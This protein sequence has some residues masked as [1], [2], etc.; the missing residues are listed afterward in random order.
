MMK[1]LPLILFLL[2]FST[3]LVLGQ[4]ATTSLRGTV[5]D[6]AGAVI[7]GA[8]ISLLEAERGFTQM[9]K[10]NAAGAY[11]F[12]Q[13]TPG[14]YAIQVTAAGFETTTS[15]GIKLVVN[16]PAT[17]DFHLKVG[18]QTVEVQVQDELAVNATDA[19]LGND[20]NEKQILELPSEGRN[21][22]D[23]LSLQPGVSYV[24]N[25][26]DTAA[27]SRGGAVN[28][29]RSD[30][31][32]ITVDGLDDNDQLLGNAFTG[33]LRIP[34]ES[35]QEFRVTTTDANAD[36]GR[37]SGAQVTLVTKTGTNQ[38]HGSFYEYNRSTI[39]QANDWFNK[40]TEL[41]NGLPDIPGKLIRNTFGA[42]LG[43]PVRKD[44]LFYFSNYEGQRLRETQQI[45]ETVPSAALR[46]GLVSYD[47]DN[48]GIATLN[49]S[50][51]ASIDQGCLSSGTCPSGNGVNQSV[52]QLWAGKA[53]LPNG[54]AIPAYPMPNN[55]SASVSGA[56]GLNIQ[57]YNFAAPHPIDQNTFV[58][59]LDYSLTGDSSQRIFVRGNLQDD[60][61]STPP[62]FPGQAPSSIIRTN[63]KG[64]AVGF[65][66]VISPTLINNLRYAYVRQGVNTGGQ[67]Q[68]PYVSFWDI[69]NQIAFTPTT[70]VNVPVNQ[71]LEDVTKT[72]SNHTF[73][74]GANWRIIENNRF[75]NAQNFTSASLHPTWLQQGGIA[76]TGQDLDP[77]INPNL[78]PVGAD[79]GASYDAAITAVTGVLGSITATY[80]QTKDGLLPQEALVP[81]H[82]K[83][84]ELE[85]YAQDN[86][87]A[88]PN[89][90]ITFGL[91]YTLLQP[92][93]ETQG[94]QVAPSPSLNSFFEKRGEAMELGQTYRPLITFTPSGKANG[95]LP[96]WQYDYKDI[97]PR[98]ALAYS[99]NGLTGFAHTIF[100]DKGK[101]SIRA[102]FGIYYDHFGEG[103]V[104]TFDRQG[105]LG[106]TTSL[107]NPST[108]ST[109][110]CAVRFV[111]LTTIPGTNGCPSSLGGPPV[112]EL[113]A[114]P[115]AGFPYTP[116]GMNTNGSFAIGFGLD[117]KLKT[118]YSY[119][120]DLSFEREMPNH[121][122]LELSYVGR[123]GRRLLQEVDLA[124]PLNIKD[125]QS[126]MTYFQAATLITKMADA[127]TPE[128]RVGKIAYWENMFPNAAG[129]S[130]A[131]GYAPGAPGNPTATQNIYDLYYGY[132]DNAAL[133]L[134]S[135]DTQCF[136]ACSKLGQFAYYDDQFSSLY[137]W[138]ST[139]VSSY[140]AFELTVRRQVGSL[141]AD[142][143]YTLS[144]SL[145]ENS[146]AE[147]VN[148][149][150]NG[151]GAAVAF[152]G[153]VVNAWSPNQFYAPS[154][155]DTRH[156][157]NANAIY[158]LPFGRGKHWGSE[159]S[160]L[161]DG[162]V[163]G[164]QL[165]GLTRWSSGYPFSISTYAFATDF[166]QD[167]KAVLTGP[168]P[169]TGVYYDAAG[170]PNVFQ[171]GIKAISSFRNAYPGEAGQ[172]NNLRGPGYFG[173]DGS[174]GKVWKTWRNQ[175]LRFSW[176][177]FN[178]TNSV[179]MD[180][181]SLSNYLF[182]AP[183]LGYYS[184]TLSKP[185][186]MQFGL[187]YAF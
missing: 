158:D 159:S 95:S 46:Q 85:F 52:L 141:L 61:E 96:Y 8:E 44:R 171:N 40:N 78:Q 98:V 91:R 42:T 77:A 142:F 110:D 9:N 135:M 90:Q 131:S 67:N 39:G 130:G 156:Q 80:N 97:A 12:L 16:T 108:I 27:D 86:W 53:S 176:D 23:L 49:Q 59:R 137:S 31:T 119:G 51:I 29:A 55:L 71:F 43:G 3:T 24:G 122:V 113:P 20:F 145:D 101:S 173:I 28:G 4:T 17:L 22:V 10:S 54:M 164:W 123:L 112:P 82:F 106:L 100:G 124:T 19:S 181:G 102:G 84:N 175:Q 143:N 50:D 114:P 161:I 133:A 121:I 81:R 153:Q 134:Q 15:K 185:R 116:P 187:H 60:T 75:S 129:A 120:F 111:S 88:S 68:Y 179:R 26:V 99:P 146:N 74:F 36:A 138:R 93:Y 11:Q 70:N 21:A 166:E 107:T 2:I 184:Q 30:Q 76:N 47:L 157:I 168:K 115:M 48:G 7:P 127:G 38:L 56:D 174:L 57:G 177:T 147:R 35:L 152:S 162:I 33:V 155:F 64:I 178:V 186:V 163:G 140:N 154:D 73:Q 149:F 132:A 160:R 104:N 94:N 6:G 13:I 117:D 103:I 118:P 139:G 66:S 45:A 32:N 89:L 182:Y 41:Q 34:M 58:A 128:N 14:T 151:S 65:T 79:F 183:S 169:K 63:N 172:R 105:S 109:T 72:V 167:G 69:S 37:S 126:G 180:V 148:E 5:Y 25:N 1:K 165:S 136:P 150:E 87:R 62:Q 170:N 18:T 92:P 125:P 144:K 83:A